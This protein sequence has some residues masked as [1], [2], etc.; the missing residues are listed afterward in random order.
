MEEG[1]KE[2]VGRQDLY[3]NTSSI[4]ALRLH[5]SYSAHIASRSLFGRVW[6]GPSGASRHQ[7]GAV[8]REHAAKGREPTE[9][10]IRHD[11]R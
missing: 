11:L 1:E 9:E 6:K 4:T 8:S 2:L 3:S 5:G 7:P 10:E